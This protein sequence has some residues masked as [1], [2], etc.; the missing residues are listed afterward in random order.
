M[1]TAA[2]LIVVAVAWTAVGFGVA[3]L[4]GGVFRYANIGPEEFANRS[5]YEHRLSV[6]TDRKRNV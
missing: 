4:L 3:I 1:S 5:I 2:L 6:V